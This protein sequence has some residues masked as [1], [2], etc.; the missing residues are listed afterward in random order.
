MKTITIRGLEPMLLEKLKEEAGSKGKSV[1]QFV[2]NILKQKFGFKKKKQ[3]TMIHTDLDH[4][5]GKWSEDEFK[6]I[7][8]NI[9]KDRKIDRELWE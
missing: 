8:G 7:Q 6:L 4:L 5:F 1:N 9:E 2:L 3:F